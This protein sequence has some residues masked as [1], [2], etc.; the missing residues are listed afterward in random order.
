MIT[1]EELKYNNLLIITS[2][3]EGEEKNAIKQ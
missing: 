3:F 1:G 2:D